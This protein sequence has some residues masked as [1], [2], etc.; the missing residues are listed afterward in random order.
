M[1]VIIDNRIVLFY[2]RQYLT[3]AGEKESYNVNDLIALKNQDLPHLTYFD[4]LQV[5]V[6]YCYIV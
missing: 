5:H 1:C 2:L 4:I 3:D 6:P